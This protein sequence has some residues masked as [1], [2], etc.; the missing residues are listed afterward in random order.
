MPVMGHSK[1]WMI[2]VPLAKALVAGGIK[3]AGNHLAY[4]YPLDAIPAISQEVKR[5]DRC[6]GTITTPESIKSC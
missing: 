1:F 3:S 5:G 4:T 2:A 6:A